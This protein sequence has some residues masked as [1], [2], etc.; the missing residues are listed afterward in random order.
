MEDIKI[1]RASRSTEHD[2]TTVISTALQVLP[3]SDYR[4][5]VFLGSPVAGTLTYSTNPNPTSG[6]GINV[7]AGV[8]G[9][10]L[11]IQDD[12]DIVRKQW[13]VVD[14]GTSRRGCVIET[15]LPAGYNG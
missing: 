13:W 11:N 5:E 1:G 9:R 12:G 7:S 14:D 3:G 15:L 2:F 8:G 4:I 6:L 10:T